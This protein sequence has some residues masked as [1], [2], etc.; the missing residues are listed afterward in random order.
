VQ[1]TTV[2][3]DANGTQKG[4]STVT[5]NSVSGTNGFFYIEVVPVIE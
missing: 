1:S 5:D 4:A 3:E 2:T